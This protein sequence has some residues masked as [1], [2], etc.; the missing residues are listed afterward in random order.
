MVFLTICIWRF[1]VFG[2][3]VRVRIGIGIGI[4]I[5]IRF[6]LLACTLDLSH[7]RRTSHASIDL[8]VEASRESCFFLC[9]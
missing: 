5:R 3:C 4:G 6:L 9:F 2:L 7:A 8:V 1:L